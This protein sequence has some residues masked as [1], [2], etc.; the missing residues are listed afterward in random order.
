MKVT[1]SKDNYVANVAGFVAV[2]HSVLAVLVKED[3]SFVSSVIE[4]LIINKDDSNKEQ[5]HESNGPIRVGG[6]IDPV[7]QPGANGP[8]SPVAKS[9][10]GKA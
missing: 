9:K 7:D 1:H 4:N 3:G 6:A 2:S 5:K 8:I 10:K